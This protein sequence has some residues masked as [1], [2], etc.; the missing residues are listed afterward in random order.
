MSL[1]DKPWTH[2]PFVKVG[3][4]VRC[5]LR[6]VGFSIW[7]VPLCSTLFPIVIWGMLTAILAIK[8]TMLAIED[9]R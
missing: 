5:I 7:F 9:V 2:I 4:L 3:K 8:K 6:I 1:S